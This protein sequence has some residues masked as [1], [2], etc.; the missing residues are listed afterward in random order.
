MPSHSQV[1]D[2]DGKPYGRLQNDQN[3]VVVSLKDVSPHFIDAII[4]RE[5]SRFWEHHGV[6]FFG[7]G[8]AFLRNLRNDGRREGA[9]TITQQLARNSLSLG[10]QNLHRKLIEAMVA[11]RIEEK[12]TKEQILEFYLN[13]IYLGSG[14]Y[15]VEAAAQKYFGKP[16]QAV[17][18][19]GIRD[20]RGHR[21]QSQ[22]EFSAQEYRW[23]DVGPRQRARPS[24]HA[25]K[26]ILGRRR[27]GK[28]GAHQAVPRGKPRRCRKTT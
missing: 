23:C 18:P 25:K 21:A 16:A 26:S 3:R 14:V 24:G 9:S 15:G 2:G 12:Y 7:I 28:S 4:A 8:R 19:R 13:R 6:D 10:G 11:N 5:D 1:F 20:A 27:R 22:P 17:D